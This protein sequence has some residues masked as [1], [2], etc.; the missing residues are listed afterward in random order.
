MHIHL[1]IH[2]LTCA[3]SPP[4]T[5]GKTK[6]KYHK[7]SLP[8]AKLFYIRCF[9]SFQRTVVLNVTGAKP[10]PTQLQISTVALCI[11][12][13]GWRK[14]LNEVCTL[15]TAWRRK[16]PTFPQGK[17]SAD[18]FL[19]LGNPTS[20]QIMHLS[21]CYTMRNCFSEFL[22]TRVE[23]KVRIKNL[24]NTDTCLSTAEILFLFYFYN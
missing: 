20:V 5:F 24:V 1:C 4:I 19:S 16:K 9:F 6:S 8:S 14:Q 2:T 17:L 11:S 18:V 22:I 21:Q 15:T 10:T 7:S 13:E 23:N 3:H 12:W